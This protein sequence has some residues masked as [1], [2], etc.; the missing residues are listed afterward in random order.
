MLYWPYFSK[1]LP[2]QYKPTPNYCYNNP[3]ATAKRQAKEI[4]KWNECKWMKFI[5]SW[6][7]CLCFGGGLPLALCALPLAAALLFL[8][9]FFAPHPHRAQRNEKKW[10]VCF[11]FYSISFWILFIFFHFS[12]LFHVPSTLSLLCFIK[13]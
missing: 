1:R 12:I 11:I 3:S 8:F 13:R 10:R 6:A 5:C 9:L 7:A 4:N 2:S